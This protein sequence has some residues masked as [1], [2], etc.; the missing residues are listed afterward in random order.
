MRSEVFSVIV[1]RAPVAQARPRFTRWGKVH[2]YDK[3]NLK[4]KA[5]IKDLFY[6]AVQ[7]YK[8][9]PQF[10]GPVELKLRFNI[11]RPPAHFG[12][13]R[14]NSR[15]L[16]SAPEYPTKSDVDNYTKFV[17]DC[18]NTRLFKDD[19]QV[20]SLT[21]EKRFSQVPSTEIEAREIS[22]NKDLERS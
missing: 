4:K 10:E 17:M 13:G 2:A 1:P 7:K 14:N 16:P 19:R 22:I 12:T 20:V 3:Q 18:L 15:V 9:L 5:F 11:A 21:A 8:S 6:Q